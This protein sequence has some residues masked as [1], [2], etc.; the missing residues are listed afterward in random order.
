[1]KWPHFR[2]PWMKAPKPITT[3]AVVQ[4]GSAMVAGIVFASIAEE[5]REGAADKI[6]TAIEMAIHRLDSPFFDVIF[7]TATFI[8]SWSIMVPAILLT[9]ACVI[10][11]KKKRIAIILAINALAILGSN[12]GLKLIFVRARPSLFEKITAP[13]SYSFP[14]GH[15]MSA[16]GIYGVI[17]AVII[18]FFPKLRLPVAIST[19]IMIFL[20]GLSRVYLGVHWPLDVVAG[21][22]AGVPPL[23]VSTHLLHRY[24]KARKSPVASNAALRTSPLAPS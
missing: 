3:R 6:D 15:S 13:T 4:L 18:Q 2:L 24:A 20:I 22:A 1:M 23:V 21:F 14:S 19:G 5:V 16:M 9:A 8:G 7:K 11:A 10:Q 17:A 12:V